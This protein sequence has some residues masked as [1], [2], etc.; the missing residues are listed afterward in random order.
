MG[1]AL[2]TYDFDPLAQLRE[3]APDWR[4]ASD[5][6]TVIA[7]V[8]EQA[9]L[10]ADELAGTWVASRPWVTRWPDQEQLPGG[11]PQFLLL[12]DLDEKKLSQA[13]TLGLRCNPGRG[14]GPLG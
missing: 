14:G 11:C 5:L 9:P 8:P 1:L 3:Y 6:R 13:K 10:M 4:Q 7:S 2:L 12:Q